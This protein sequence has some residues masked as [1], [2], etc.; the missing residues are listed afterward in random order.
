MF[1]TV[2]IVL[3]GRYLPVCDRDNDRSSGP[4]RN[5]QERDCWL[6]IDRMLDENYESNVAMQLWTAVGSGNV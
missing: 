2:P 1:T 5:Q 3:N 6:A 4:G